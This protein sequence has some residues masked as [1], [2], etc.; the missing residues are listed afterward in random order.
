MIPPGW[1]VT[2]PIELACKLVKVLEALSSASQDARAF[3]SKIDNF[4]RSL[5]QLQT[6]LDDAA[7]GNVDDYDHLRATL[8]ECKV[9]VERCEDFSRDFEKL[10]DGSGSGKLALAG[11]AT[12]WVWQEG[13]ASK[14][15]KEIDSQMNDIT[16]L[17]LIKS[18]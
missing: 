12:R 17:L 10:N 2:E 16:F 13:K 11:Q 6:K 18:L 1:N 9:C 14:L 4:R 5:S 8:V 7:L 15:R 3:V